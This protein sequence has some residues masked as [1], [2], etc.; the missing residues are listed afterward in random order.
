MQNSNISLKTLQVNLVLNPGTSSGARQTDPIQSFSSFISSLSDKELYRKCQYYGTAARAWRQK[1]IGLLP[2]VNRRRLYENKGFDT[3]FEFAFKL[4]GLSDK[5]VRLALNLRERVEDKPALKKMLENGEVSMNKLAR[6]VS[7]ATP[8]NE[9]E[10]AEKVK[11]LPKSALE[12][13]VRDEKCLRKQIMEADFGKQNAAT[14]NENGSQ[15]PLFGDKS[16][17]GHDLNFEIADDIKEQLNELHLKG[18][19]VNELLREMLKRRK[20]KIEKEKEEIAKTIQQ[21]T[22]HYI[23]TRIQRVLK[24]EH[25]KKCSITT[26]QKPATVIHHTQRFSLSRNHDPRFLAPL[27]RE[28]HIIAH[29]IDIKYQK[30]KTSHPA[31]GDISNF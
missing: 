8:E 18:I 1:F 22:S 7:I 11:V 19:D 17:P 4:C 12:T 14:K 26:C 27:C 29:S 23:S 24:E 25:G 21:T 31:F 28:H 15:K 10:L 2:E 5:Q 6:V 9:E 20:E 30:I 13:L 3:I 16:L